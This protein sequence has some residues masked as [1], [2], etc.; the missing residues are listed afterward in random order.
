MFDG[1]LLGFHG[2]MEFNNLLAV[3]VGCFVGTLVGIL[4]GIGPTG[5]MA[6]LLPLT[7]ALGPTA[8]MIMLAGIWYGAQYG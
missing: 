2:I 7:Y 8:G 4:P 3:V 6:L 5:T 1:L